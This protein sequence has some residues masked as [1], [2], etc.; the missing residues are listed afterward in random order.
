MSCRANFP[1]TFFRENL[2]ALSCDTQ[3][4]DLDRRGYPFPDHSLAVI[5]WLDLL[6]VAFYL[7]AYSMI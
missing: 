7:S 4:Y 2:F 6:A 1:E 3:K 5:N